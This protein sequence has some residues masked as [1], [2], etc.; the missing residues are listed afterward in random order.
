MARRPPPWRS[1]GWWRRTHVPDGLELAAWQAACL[2]RLQPNASQFNPFNLLVFDGHQL[3][4]FQ[5]RHGRTLAMQPGLCGVSNAD[6]HTP[7]PKLVRLQQ[8]LGHH[9]TTGDTSDDVLM[10]LLANRSLASDDSLP[11][12]GLPL[13]RE[14]VLSAAFIARPPAKARAGG[15]GV[16]PELAD[17]VGHENCHDLAR[18]PCVA[19]PLPRGPRVCGTFRGACGLRHIR[20][21]RVGWLVFRR[22]A[23][24]ACD[25]LQDALARPVHSRSHGERQGGQDRSGPRA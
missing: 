24:P 23:G 1:S 17:N 4:G 13:E 12:T 15:M 19:P 18:S 11:S 21:W 6:F 5:S 14:R 22:H 2:G 25:E 20:A 9:L 16:L 7:W 3:L 10:A 8:G